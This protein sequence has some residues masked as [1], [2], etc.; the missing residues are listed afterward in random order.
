M[1][2]SAVLTCALA[3][4]LALLPGLFA[5]GSL[6]PSGPPAPSLKSLAQIEPRIAIQSLAGDADSLYV[7]TQPGSY[8]LTGNLTATDSRNAIK[9]ASGVD[10][11]IDLGG[12][13]LDGAN[14]GGH[15]IVGTSFAGSLSVRNGRILR[16]GGLAVTAISSGSQLADLRIS[17]CAGGGLN[18]SSHAH[19]SACVV[20]NC[21][22]VSGSPGIRT[23]SDSRILDCVVAS[24]RA[25]GHGISVDYGS[26]VTGTVSGENGGCGILTTGGFVVVERCLCH[27]NS[28]D[29][30]RANGSNPSVVD[31]HATLNTQNGI[32]LTNNLG[33][34]D[35]CQA[36]NNFQ[37][38][39]AVELAGARVFVV[40][41]TATGNTV[42]NYAIAA[43]NRP[44]QIIT[45]SAANGFASGDPMA[46]GQ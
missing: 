3:V 35:R 18:L 19:I 23:E 46:N 30:I 7:I 24:T 4:S 20:R 16:W 6:T 26:L 11:W 33:R 31:C 8:Y 1:L 42:N 5:Q 44:A 21:S 36:S 2:R 13:V 41:N 9:I 17:D 28:L 14:V 34:I 39:I 37:N 43:N 40:R 22:A 38:G 29:G 32:R 12:F 15:A 25:A 27:G 10:V 45:W